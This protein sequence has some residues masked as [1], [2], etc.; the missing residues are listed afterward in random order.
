MRVIKN[1]MNKPMKESY[2]ITCENCESELEITEDDIESYGFLGISYVTCPICGKST[3]TD[4]E[5]LDKKI[6][7]DNMVFPDNFY[8]FGNGVPLSPE[9]IN[10]YIKNG[11]KYFRENPSSFAYITG[12]GDTFVAVCN[13]S[14]DE[15]YTVVVA[16]GYY[17]GEIP[18][19]SEDYRVQDRNN[20]EWK[21]T[22]VAVWKVHKREY[23]NEMAE[24]KA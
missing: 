15:Q 11:V 22:G 21:N 7:L 13:Y 23:E 3:A 10:R 8:S 6:T 5:E 4:I 18:Y 24:H 2:K 1:N 17:E 12:S 14:G 9:D 16:K 20:W 19:D